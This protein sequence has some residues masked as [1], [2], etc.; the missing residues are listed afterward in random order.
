MS[1]NDPASSFDFAV[2][3]G[4]MHAVTDRYDVDYI[5]DELLLLSFPSGISES[6]RGLTLASSTP[7]PGLTS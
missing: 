1:R 6:V 3:A 4:E 2:P 7:L 5:R